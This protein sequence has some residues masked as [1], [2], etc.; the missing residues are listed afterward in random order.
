MPSKASNKIEIDGEEVEIDFSDIE[1]RFAVKAP[2]TLGTLIVVDGAPVVDSEKKTKLIEVIKK[3]F[4][5]IGT[6]K[7]VEMPMD[8]ATG[9]SKG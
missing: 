8:S 4:K 5:N 2:D 6:V 9:K 7:N 1:A 3:V